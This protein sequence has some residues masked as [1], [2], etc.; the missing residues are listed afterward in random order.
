MT[1][2]G[3]TTEEFDHAFIDGGSC[4]LSCEC[5][6]THFS[7]QDR[8][9]FSDDQAELE[10]LLKN[11]ESNPDKYVD[12]GDES[13]AMGYIDGHHLVLGCPCGEL[14]KYEDFIWNNRRRIL[15]Y[16][17]TRIA[18]Q[19]RESNDMNVLANSVGGK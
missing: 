9:G 1:N 15:E 19:A 5:G 3:Q 2:K 16:L 7:S 12:H 18:N 6:R 11:A 17:K 4:W 10:K 14:A 13:V 8:V